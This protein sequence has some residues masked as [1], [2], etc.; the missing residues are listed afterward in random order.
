MKTPSCPA[1]QHPL[2]AH[3]TTCPHC[4]ATQPP[5]APPAAAKVSKWQWYGGLALLVLG[6]LS[7]PLIWY[8]QRPALVEASGAQAAVARVAVAPAASAPA[9]EVSACGEFPPQ[10]AQQ[11]SSPAAA[12][13]PADT[14]LDPGPLVAACGG[15]AIAVQGPDATLCEHEETLQDGAIAAVS[16]PCDETMASAVAS[17]GGAARWS[18]VQT[19]SQGDSVDTMTAILTAKRQPYPG[20]SF[21]KSTS[22]ILSRGPGQRLRAMLEVDDGRFLCEDSCT[23][24]IRFDQSSAVTWRA[25]PGDE[26]QQLVLLDAPKLL[27]RLREAQSMTVDFQIYRLEPQTTRF[28]NVT[29]LRLE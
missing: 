22:L 16:G 27:A 21:S 19:A 5:S 23:V 20:A 3:V 25:K 2:P 13:E 1:C 11:A 17:A 26:L 9:S 8:V 4:G 12:I 14:S 10:P 29:G 18:Y 6:L 15:T 24:R 7:L 28:D